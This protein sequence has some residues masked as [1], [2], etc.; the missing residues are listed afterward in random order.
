VLYEMLT[1]RPAFAG[2]SVTETLAAVLER[3]VDFTTLPPATT[4]SVRTVL[5]RS[6]EKDPKRRLHDIADA[7]IELDDTAAAATAPDRDRS[8]TTQ[9]WMVALAAG[10]A[11]AVVVGVGAWYLGSTASPT[12]AGTAD[13][14]RM[15]IA[16]EHGLSPG[17]D[18]V[19]ALS[20]DGRVLAYVSNNDGRRQIYLHR[21]NEFEGRPIPGTDRAD[22]LA[23]SP[24]GASLAFTADQQV[25]K[26]AVDGGA[27]IHL[28]PTGDGHGLIWESDDTILFNPGPAS[29]ISRVSAGGG[30]P[31]VVTRLE[32]G[33]LDHRPFDILPAGKTVLY[34]T[35]PVG[36]FHSWR[37]VAQSLESGARRVIPGGSGA[38]YLA[39]TGHLLY[40]QSGTVYAVRFDPLRP[41]VTGT[42]T[43]VLQGVRQMSDGTA[44]IAF[45]L[46]GSMMYVP[47]GEGERRDT[48]VWVDRTG[49]EHP[50]TV[51]SPDYTWMP[52]LMPDLRRA[53]VVLEGSTTPGNA[54]SDVWLYD[55]MGGPRRRLTL[56]GTSQ[57]SVWSPDGRRLAYTSTRSGRPAIYVRTLD[58]ETETMVKTNDQ[59][60]LPFSWS[61]DGRFLAAVSINPTTTA[62]D[63]WVYDIDD[64]SRSR[65]FAATQFRE[66]APTFSHDGRFIAYV[67]EQT[68]RAEIVMR[69][70]PG[71]GNEI[72][73]S[74]DGG[75]EPVWARKAGQLFYRQG[76]A[77]MVVDITTTPDVKVG[78]P[79]RIFERPFNRSTAFWPN[80]DVTPDGQRFLMVKDSALDMPPTRIN[81]VFNWVEE[82]KGLVPA[83]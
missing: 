10:V 29:G 8:R 1:G 21:L 24:D 66:G 71:P 80:Y 37:V 69:P 41:E 5:R 12:T 16:P 20:P 45:S 25:K 78:V 58:T 4:A 53:G 62:N 75:K 36:A 28:C 55:L 48:L 49:V 47:A 77:M 32:A 61:P 59:T 9:T 23:F 14:T 68:G 35:T 79:R 30:A 7:R 52:R 34:T 56:D 73:I 40:A 2:N 3:N 19:L 67:S 70:F 54:Q 46:T 11:T 15:V 74:T 44:Q 39:A 72:A 38:R 81:V 6:L 27:P 60:N 82:L 33:E 83:N 18:G 64:P 42:P 65:A 57:T 63:I 22:N 76:D 26:V 43:V 31:A 13:V 17:T 50:T 51:S